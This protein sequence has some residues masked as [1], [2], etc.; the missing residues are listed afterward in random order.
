MS[1]VYYS[2]SDVDSMMANITQQM[3]TQML[4]PHVILGPGRGGFPIG[5]MLSHYFDIP[6]HGFEWQ[7][8]DGKIQ[9]SS[10]LKSLL[11][12]YN[13]KRVIVIDDIND[14]GTTLNGIHDIVV[15]EG[16]ENNVKYITLFDKLSSNFGNVSITA[17]ELDDIEEKQWIV[18]PYEEW[19][20]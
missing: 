10:Q 20:K 17:K 4:R 14:T 6:F 11:S 9:N 2:W 15:M 3:A 12:K 18:F 7:T 13:S 1:K 8:R 16:M 19:W 5:V